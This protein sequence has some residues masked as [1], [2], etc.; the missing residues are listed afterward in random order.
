MYVEH[1]KFDIDKIDSTGDSF[2]D[3]TRK[4][5]NELTSILKKSGVKNVDEADEIAKEIINISSTNSFLTKIGASSMYVKLYNSDKLESFINNNRRRVCLDTQVLLRLFCAVYDNSGYDYSFKSVKKLHNLISST[6]YYL[7]VFTTEYYIGEVAAH[8][9]KA[10]KICN[11]INLPIFKKVGKTRNVF[12]NFYIELKEDERIDSNVNFKQFVENELLDFNLPDE[13]KD[14]FVK[15]V[16]KRI[17][18]LFEQLNYEVVSSQYHNNFSEIKTRFEKNLGF[19][20]QTRSQL[21][22]KHDI[23]ATLFMSDRNNHFDTDEEIF[24]EPYFVTWDN[25]FYDLRNIARDNLED[26][27]HWFVYTPQKF[28]EKIQLSNFKIKPESINETILSIL[29]SDF[30]SSNYK[31]SFLDVISAIFNK[32]NVSDL[33]LAQKFVSIEEDF[34]KEADEKNNFGVVNIEESPL[35]AVLSIL[36]NNYSGAESENSMNEF[37]E[38]CEDNSKADDLEKIVNTAI[39]E[40]ENRKLDREKLLSDV[41]LLIGRT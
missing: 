15:Q 18:K 1:F 33:K 13:F 14:N 24:L 22:I 25:Q 35:T 5:F 4:I 26:Y 8:L 27:Q 36:I 30:N 12:Y 23:Q 32:E 31:K 40:Y 17:I 19:K 9:Q 11:Y 38:L 41:N 21:A 34:L 10:L 28:I 7:D 6:D 37:I 29:E 2:T 20:N 3:S 16:E 39:Y